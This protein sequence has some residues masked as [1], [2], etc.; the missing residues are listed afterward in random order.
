MKIIE[1]GYD[2]IFG[3]RSIKH[4]VQDKIEDILAKKIVEGEVSGGEELELK[5]EDID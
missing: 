1:K 3:A 5:P 2:P 4:F